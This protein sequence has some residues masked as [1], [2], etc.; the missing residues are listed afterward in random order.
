MTDESRPQLSKVFFLKSCVI[1]RALVVDM[2]SYIK[3]SED[4]GKTWGTIPR[5]LIQGTIPITDRQ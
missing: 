3:I 5:N 1:P 4:G 2:G